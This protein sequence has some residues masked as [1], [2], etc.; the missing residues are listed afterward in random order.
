MQEQVVKI[1]GRSGY[2]YG[3]ICR[4]ERN[5]CNLYIS[6]GNK[7]DLITSTELVLN[8]CG[9][10][11]QP[12]PVF[13]ADKLSR[14]YMKKIYGKVKTFTKNGGNNQNRNGGNNQNRNGGNNQ[15]RNG[16]NNQNRN[17]GNNQNRNGGNVKI[18]QLKP[19]N[20]NGGNGKKY[21][22][23]P[24]SKPPPDTNTNQNTDN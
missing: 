10:M 1:K 12:L 15:N 17:G 20:K 9:N 24:Q 8:C 13:L 6:Q 3:N 2:I 23:K 18:Y 4:C 11:D 16:G 7:I 21:Q 22:L 14:D 19:Q 5:S